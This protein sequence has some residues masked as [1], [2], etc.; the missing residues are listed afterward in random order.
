VQGGVYGSVRGVG[1]PR[2]IDNPAPGHRRRGRGGRRRGTL[3]W[4]ILLVR[5]GSLAQAGKPWSAVRAGSGNRP[6]MHEARRSQGL[7][8][9][10]L[11]GSNREEVEAHEGQVSHRDIKR[12][13]VM[14]PI[15]ARMKAL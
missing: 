5:E 15:F 6:G 12:G 13:L 3:G 11:H 7:R 9:A 14:R 8:S 1:T 4:Q 10:R 2:G